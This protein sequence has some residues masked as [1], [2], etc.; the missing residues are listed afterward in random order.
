MNLDEKKSTGDE[1]RLLSI[2]RTQNEIAATELDL[3]SAMQVVTERAQ[4]LTG[5]SGAIVQLPECEV[6]FRFQAT[7]G[8]CGPFV[9]QRL[10]RVRSLAGLALSL[11]R[12]LESSDARSD[13]R[14]DRQVTRAMNIGS[15]ICVPLFHRG[16]AIGVL[17]VVH[18]GADHF[19]ETDRQALEMMSDLI[20]AQMAH[21]NSFEV[22]AHES[23]HDGLT[24][25]GEAAQ[26]GSHGAASTARSAGRSATSTPFRCA[27]STSTASRRSTIV[28]ATLPVTRSCAASPP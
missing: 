10:D 24:G 26:Q 6:S 1:Q 25:L 11:R 17:T 14:V 18:P 15:M 3:D 23:R 2:I 27:C 16:D 7:S 12:P 5:A 4:E 9:G 21:A 19:T 28:T 20:A 22:E 13:L 8:E